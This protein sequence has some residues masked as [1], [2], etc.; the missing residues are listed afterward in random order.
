M[1][2]IKRSKSSSQRQNWEK[3]FSALVHMLQTQQKQLETLI[4]ERKL[5]EDRIRMQHDR[6]SSDTRLYEDLVYQLQA[7]LVLRDK[8]RSLEASKL[9]LNMSLKQRESFLC[10]VISDQTNNELQD[11]KELFILLSTKISD[12]S[13]VSSRSSLQTGKSNEK[14]RNSKALKIEVQRLQKAYE[15]LASERSSE[16]TALLAEKTFVWNQYSIMENDYESKLRQNLTEVE[17]ARTKIENLLANMEQLQSLNIEK[18]CTI[19]ALESQLKKTEVDSRKLNDEISRISRELEVLRKHNGVSVTPVL[20]R[21]TSGSGY[22]TC[23]LGVNKKGK[24]SGSNI[25]VRKKA[26]PV[27]ASRGNG[28]SSKEDESFKRR[29]G[30]IRESETPRLFTSSFKPPKLRS[31]TCV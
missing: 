31:T 2:K 11:F 6:W 1:G 25:N 5:L 18:D 13:D 15:K 22:R 14:T 10:Q 28:D 4:E 8:Q 26:S 9:D 7:D 24:G 27:Q 16:V 23:S 12:P 30:L 21:C 20:N 19:A 29:R 17:L 3:I